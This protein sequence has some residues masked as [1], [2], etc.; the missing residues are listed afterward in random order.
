MD[1]VSTGEDR[2][3]RVYV[4]VHYLSVARRQSSVETMAEQC[5]Y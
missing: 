2:R 4:E 1:T 3:V 5:K